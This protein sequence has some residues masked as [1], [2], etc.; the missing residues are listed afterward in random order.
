MPTARSCRRWCG[1][2]L[3][4]TLVVSLAGCE[5]KSAAPSKPETAAPTTQ[6]AAPEAARPARPEFSVAR[7]ADAPLR[8]MC[9]NVLWNSM[10]PEVSPTLAEKFGRLVQAVKPDVLIL[11]EI[12]THPQDRDKPDA[13]HYTAEDVL[14]QMNVVYPLGDGQQWYAHQGADDVIVSRYP[15]SLT[16]TATD[17]VGERD[18]AIALVDLPDDQFPVDLYIMANHFKC[19]GDTQ[20]DGRRQQQADSIIAWLRDARTPGGHIDLPADTAVIVGGDL[21]IV[22]SF[23]PVKTLITGDIQDEAAYGVDF[24]PDADGTALTDLEPRHNRYEEETYTWRD[25]TSEYGPGRLDYIIYSDA[26]LDAVNK[27]ILDTTTMT[28]AEL[29]AAGL[30]KYDVCVDN[31]GKE[32]DHL[33]MVVDFKP[34]K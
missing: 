5:S 26:V 17:P 33:P 4:L 14:R 12:G 10:F 22:G 29:A 28:D 30:Q 1:A 25:D 13:R 8:V 3:M 34:V 7:P 9:Y 6:P 16:A 27:F 18:Q 15:L 23:Q 2:A 11:E 31:V 24:A 20:N 19:C 21:N 32:F